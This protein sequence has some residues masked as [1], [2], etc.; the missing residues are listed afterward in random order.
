MIISTH[1]LRKLFNFKLQS[2]TFR[3]AESINETP[4][5]YNFVKL[6]TNL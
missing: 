6:S 5:N 3:V 2:K 1:I 4:N